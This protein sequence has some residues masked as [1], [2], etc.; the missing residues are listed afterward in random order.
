MKLKGAEIIINVLKEEGVEVVFGYPGGA[1]LNIYD[2][3]YNHSEEIKHVTSA[4]EQGA[5]HAADGYAR[6]TGKVGVVIATSGPGATNLV[7]G[8][9]TA[10]LDSVPLVALTGNV[11]R[12]LLG[13]DSFQEVNISKIAEPVTK[14]STVADDPDTLADT[15]RKAF[16]IARSGRPRPVLVD[17]PKDITAL[18]GEYTPKTPEVDPM[19]K[20]DEG[21]TADAVKILADAKRPVILAGGGVVRGRAE[22]ALKAFAERWDAP[23]GNTLMGTGLLDGHPLKMGMV[24]MHGRASATKACKHADVLVAVGTRFSDRVATDKD[25]FLSEDTKVI[26]IDLDPGEMGKNIG[27]KIKLQGNVAEVLNLLT[28]KMEKQSHE[29]WK[30]EVAGWQQRDFTVKE[31]N[32]TVH[33]AELIDCICNSLPNRA[34]ITTDVGQHQMW[35]AQYVKHV[36]AERFLTSGGLG[37]MGYGLGAAIGAQAANP[38]AKVVHLTGDGSFHMNCNELCT[39]VSRNFPIITVI[40]NNHALGMVR[41]WQKVFYGGRY[42]ETSLG[43]QTDYVKLAKAYGGKGYRTETLAEFRLAFAEALQSDV[44]V[45]IDALIN[46]DERVLPMIPAG[47]SLEA[48]ILK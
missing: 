45:V 26:H 31:E 30:N 27:A 37:T 10:Y 25:A 5:C 24:G 4:H 41:Q 15:L 6:V 42:S 33:P 48:V 16:R 40:F 13:L 38:N 22:D 7:T 44:P 39:A 35:A 20:A 14:W 3:L 29:D 1:V 12:E 34:I 43:R 46:E 36:R 47:K 18:E 2:A 9:A 11:N 17:I 23:V 19:P 21:M 32:S 28:A 8:L